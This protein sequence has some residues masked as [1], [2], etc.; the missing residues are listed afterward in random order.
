[1]RGN[2]KP[3]PGEL[4]EYVLHV[5]DDTPACGIAHAQWQAE[6]Y[7]AMALLALSPAAAPWGEVLRVQRVDSR[8]APYQRLSP[9]FVCKLDGP[10]IVRW[11]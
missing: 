2:V 6:H 11:S 1:M 9:R 3:D 10:G 7:V 4:W 8:T 5:G